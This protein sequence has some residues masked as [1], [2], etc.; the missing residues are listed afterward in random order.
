MRIPSFMAIPVAFFSFT[1]GVAV[2]ADKADGK[3]LYRDNCKVCHDKGSK[4][5]EYSPLTL[6]QDQWKSF[7]K[8]KFDASH[9]N[10]IL[11]NGKRLM[12]G[13]SPAELKA[14]QK[15]AIDHAADSEHPQTCS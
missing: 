9:K 3:A 11:P 10:A 4:N 5:G 2:A 15:F 6:I 1:L 14:L 8:E 7:F 12:D 13:L